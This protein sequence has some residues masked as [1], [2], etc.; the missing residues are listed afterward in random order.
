MPRKVILILLLL[1]PRIASAQISAA[2]SVVVTAPAEAHYYTFS[3]PGYAQFQIGDGIPNPTQCNKLGGGSSQSFTMCQGIVA[4]YDLKNDASATY[5]LR[6]GFGGDYHR[7]N[8]LN[9]DTTNRYPEATE[10]PGTVVVT[11]D[12]NVRKVL[13]MTGN[14]REVGY[15]GNP[16]DCCIVLTETWVFYRHG[17]AGAG[18]GQG[19][20]KLFTQAKLAYDGTDGKGPLNISVQD[21]LHEVGW[22]VAAGEVSVSYPWGFDPAT[23]SPWSLIYQAP[24]VGGAKD[25]ILY[26][27]VAANSANAGEFIPADTHATPNG[28]T[29]GQ[30]YLCNGASNSG[31]TS[32]TL[33]SYTVKANSLFIENEQQCSATTPYTYLSGGYRTSC[34]Y[35]AISLAAGTPRTWTYARFI[36]DNG[37]IS[38]STASPFVAEY[39]TPPT[40]TPTNA[41]GGTFDAL[42]G[43]WSLART[44]DTVSISAN[45]ILHS[46][47]WL[48]SNW[49][50]S[51]TGMTVGGV[52][53]TLNTDFVA[54]K[55]DGTHLLVQYLGDVASSTTVTFPSGTAPVITPG[56]PV[57]NQ[58]GTINFTADAAGTWACAGTD[59]TGTASACHGSIVAGTGVY[60][61]PASVTAQHMVGGFQML[62]N[63][64]IF[65]TDISGLSVNAS[66]ATW[67]AAVN[68]GG[69]PSFD[70]QGTPYNNCSPSTPTDTMSFQYTPSSNGLFEVP[71][72]PN[73]YIQAGW[74]SA[75]S[76]RNVDHHLFC[77]D[78]TSGVF[79]EIYQYYANCVTTA[80]SVTSNTAKLTCTKNPQTAGFSLG[81]SVCVGS[82]TGGD[83]YFNVCPVT[84]SSVDGVSI[85]YPLVHANGSAS[86]FGNVT[87]NSGGSTCSLAGT[88][89]SQGGVKYN[90]Y[91]YPLPNSATNAAGTAIEPLEL[92]F[93]EMEQAVANS[94]TINHALLNTFGAGFMASSNIWPAT[95]FASD[96]ATVPFG[97][98]ARLKSSFNISG[99]SAI[100]QILL[101][102]LQHYGIIVTDGGT[103][104]D[105]D[106]QQ[107]AW[108]KPYTDAFLVYNSSGKNFTITNSA[109]TGNVVTITAVNDLAAGNRVDISGTTNGGGI[110]NLGN[111]S[112][113]SATGSSFTFNLTHANVGSAADTG[114]VYSYL[115]NYMEFVDESGLQISANQTCP[116]AALCGTT[117]RN[118]EIITFTRTSDSVTASVDVALQGVAVN[119]PQDYLNI[120]AGTPA[121]QLTALV[122]IGTVTWSMSPTVGTLTAGGLYTPPATVASPT[123]TTITATSVTNGAVAASMPV[124]VLPAGTIRLLVSQTTNY[125]DNGSNVWYGSLSTSNDLGTNLQYDISCCAGNNAGSFANVTD[126]NLWTW[127]VGNSSA[128]TGDNRIDITVPNGSYIITYHYGTQSPLRTQLFKLSS[129]GSIF[130]NGDPD[131]VAGGQFQFFTATVPAVVTNNKLSFVI[132]NVNDQGAPISSISIAQGSPTTGSALTSGGSFSAGTS[133]Q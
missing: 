118:R 67:M 6:N 36:G 124:Y 27:P 10:G 25:Y 7:W 80:A 22:F 114:N 12:N 93:Q 117:T 70:F 52:T 123:Q 54:V 37:I 65:N 9:S 45:G 28:P 126:K 100:A 95:T 129:Q 15:Y 101:T 133:T 64:H 42:Q 108:T 121:Q 30:L 3:F 125:T 18:V 106:R 17:G 48:I 38:E 91:D 62:P 21:F 105:I 109:L 16:A 97:A 112:V 68:V 86:S 11:E 13:T 60:T 46:P 31:C 79:S 71:Q 88:C 127:T 33:S 119:L 76:N 5:N 69:H 26:A 50:A 40:M 55:T 116:S 23:P 53:K 120:Q 99:F 1:L 35:A 122:N 19:G 14:L 87:L 66:N 96:G 83:T 85:S 130:Y 128:A 43:Y 104:W 107:T 115:S 74:F 92:T 84:L 73:V 110:F 98:R 2:S 47:A 90:Y 32:T 82:F 57:V 58:G 81:S 103:N 20:V 4:Y 111:V 94:G 41:T 29:P 75:R 56:Q 8:I 44:A 51:S 77:G 113:A 72:F 39:K 132:W 49:S 131:G 63:N 89:N 78:T 102:Q 24:G 61:A 59:N 34:T